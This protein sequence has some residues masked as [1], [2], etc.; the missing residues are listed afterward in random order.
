MLVHTHT[1]IHTTSAHYLCQELLVSSFLRI[2]LLLLVGYL[3]VI[4]GIKRP[5]A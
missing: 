4:E 5:D 2:L 1:A 3:H